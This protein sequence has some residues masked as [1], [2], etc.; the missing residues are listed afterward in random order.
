MRKRHSDHPKRGVSRRRFL[1]GALVACGVGVVW[2]A[3]RLFQRYFGSASVFDRVLF[4]CYTGHGDYSPGVYLHG[5]A[6]GGPACMDLVR[7]AARCMRSSEVGDAAAGLCG[8][9]FKRLGDD[10]A[11]GGGLS[12]YDAPKPG[13]DGKIN[14]QAYCGWNVDLILIDVDRG[15]A[16][17]YSSPN[18]PKAPSK[19]KIQQIDGLCF[20]G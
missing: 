20:G 8:F 12:L 9:L 15:I 3:S 2:C 18:D 19:N 14:W 4:V 17:C 16:E 6:G 5:A 13:A 10:V 1:V 7:D 11:A